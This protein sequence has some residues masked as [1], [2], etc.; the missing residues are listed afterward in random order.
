MLSKFISLFKYKSQPITQSPNVISIDEMLPHLI[1]KLMSDNEYTITYTY[2]QMI[3]S[4]ELHISPFLFTKIGSCGGRQY[5]HYAIYLVPDDYVKN[6]LFRTT[7]VEIYSGNLSAT[8]TRKYTGPWLNELKKLCELYDIK[9]YIEMQKQR[10]LELKLKLQNDAI[11]R[12]KI[13]DFERQQLLS[14]WS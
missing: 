13:K 10:E 1:E 2:E 14:R 3:V 7:H 8:Y 12:Q 5:N 11:E 6:T 9:Q 4:S